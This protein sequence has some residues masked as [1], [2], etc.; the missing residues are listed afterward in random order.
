MVSNQTWSIT[1]LSLVVRLLTGPKCPLI[2]LTHFLGMKS[3]VITEA[4]LFD[5][6]A[7][8]Q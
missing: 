3:L 2:L 4:S 5:Q 7:C 6:R 1:G 8:Q